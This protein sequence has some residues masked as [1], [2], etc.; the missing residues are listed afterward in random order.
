MKLAFL[1]ALSTAAA[2]AQHAADAYYDPVE[3]QRARENL[4][5][6]NGGQT[7]YFVQSD[8]FEVQSNE[9]A[10]RLV[11]EGQGWVGGDYRKLWFKSEGEYAEGGKLEEAEIQGLY[12]RAVT[13]FFDFQAGVRQD[14]APGS[15]RTFGVV[16]VQGL[17]PYWFEIDAAL[18]VSHQGDV[19]ARF[20]AEYDLRFTQRLILQPRT[21]LN[22]AVQDVEELAI[23]SG[24]STLET[25]ARLR[26]ELKR[27]VAPYI[28][29]SWLRATGRTADYLRREGEDPSSL[30][31]VVGLR[32][33]F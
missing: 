29:V 23:G 21:E 9:G 30:S 33:W 22:F 1:F 25:G 3:M 15:R 27:E 6:M 31:I 13:S 11:W 26:Y 28:G 4:R 16:G 8:R 5:R 18:F 32:L 17:A 12:S 14:V 2:L 10:G 20:E 24:L 19:S 7:N